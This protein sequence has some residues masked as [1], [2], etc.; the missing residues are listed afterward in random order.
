LGPTDNGHFG[1][2]TGRIAKRAIEISASNGTTMN[3]VVMVVILAAALRET[4]G[5]SKKLAMKPLELF[6]SR[7]STPKGSVICFQ[8]LATKPFPSQTYP[9]YTLT[10]FLKI[11]FNI[12]L[13]YMSKIC[14]LAF[15]CQIL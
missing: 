4:C 14:N 10:L 2:K 1:I 11:H 7:Q 8:N 13:K 12:I 3:T 6:R 9:A 15:F 5:V